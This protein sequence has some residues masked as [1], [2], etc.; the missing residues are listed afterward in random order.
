MKQSTDRILTTHVGSLPRPQPLLHLLQARERDEAVDEATIEAQIAH[1]VAEIVANQVATGLDIVSDGEMSKPSYTL[2]IRHRVANIVA[3]PAAAAKGRAMITGLDLLD[4][5]EMI[6]HHAVRGVAFPACKGPL[7]YR[8]RRPLE[9]DLSRFAD[10]VAASKPT[11]AFLTAPS[12]G[13]LTR[14]IVNEHYPNEDAYVAALAEAMRVE[15]EAIHRA[16]FILQVDCPDLAAARNNQYRDKTNAEFRRIA[17]RN[18][19]ILNHVLSAIPPERMR[20]HVCWGN[21]AGPHTHDI[22]LAEIIDICLNARPQA[23]SFEGANPRH[24]HEWED[25]AAINI[26]GDKI[27]IPGLIDSTSN[28]VEHPRLVAQ[29]IRRYAGIVGRERVIAGVDC[30][31]GTFSDAPS[32][33][34]SIAWAKLKTLVEGAQIASADL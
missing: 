15:Y 6:E 20:M 31:F 22:P 23:L 12:P 7:V 28:F 33:Y 1:A 2:Y 5:P 29:R 10:A 13:T 18:V 24:E 3:D 16:G 9:R 4:H 21:Y 30:G 25:L 26:P 34:P 19:E 14:F 11:E 32:V 17:A 27:L 8:D